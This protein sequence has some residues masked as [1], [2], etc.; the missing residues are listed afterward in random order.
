MTT[1]CESASLADHSGWLFF[2]PAKYR[3]ALCPPLVI[4][5][6]EI[7]ELFDRLER[8][9]AKALDWATREKLIAA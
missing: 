5:E 6:G 2:I 3:V 8:A 4:T 9:L 1:G 7:G